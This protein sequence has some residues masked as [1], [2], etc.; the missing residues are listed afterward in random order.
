MEASRCLGFGSSLGLKVL[1]MGPFSQLMH[2][3]SITY[4]HIWKFFTAVI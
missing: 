2:S 4:K 1:E 3:D